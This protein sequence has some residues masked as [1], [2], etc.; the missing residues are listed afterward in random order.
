MERLSQVAAGLCSQKLTPAERER[1]GGH[2]TA[3]YQSCAKKKAHQWQEAFW[4]SVG[5]PRFCCMLRLLRAQLCSGVTATLGRPS[6]PRNLTRLLMHF[7]PDSQ[8]LRWRWS[9]L[10]RPLCQHAAMPRGLDCV[11]PRVLHSPPQTAATDVRAKEWGDKLQTPRRT[12]RPQR[13]RRLARMRRRQ[14]FW[15]S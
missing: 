5:R 11:R 13:L 6:R 8:P 14:C 3:G 15:S 12:M 1:G 9:R 4:Y 2:A 10:Q 7:C